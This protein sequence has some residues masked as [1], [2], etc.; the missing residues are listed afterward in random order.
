MTYD[1]ALDAIRNGSRITDGKNTG[2]ALRI[3]T[4]FGND[5]IATDA[6]CRDSNFSVKYASLVV[7]INY[8]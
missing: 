4:L 6:P 1:Q 8:P 5:Y 7:G 3:L 2:R